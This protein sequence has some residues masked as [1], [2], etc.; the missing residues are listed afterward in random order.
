MGVD[1]SY[2]RCTSYDID[3]NIRPGPE[4]KIVP[5]RND[6]GRRIFLNLFLSDIILRPEFDETLRIFPE[7]EVTVVET[8][9]S[10]KLNGK[11]DY[12][13]EGK[14]MFDNTILREIYVVAVEAKTKFIDKD[15]WQC[16]AEAASLYKTNS[17]SAYGAIN[18][19]YNNGNS[20]LSMKMDFRGRKA[21]SR[22]LTDRHIFGDSFR[23]WYFFSFRSLLRRQFSLLDQFVR[24]SF[25]LLLC[26]F[27]CIF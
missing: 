7:L 13:V 1:T 22:Y 20:F 8:N 9:D 24:K 21:Y 23:K 5:Q 6:A 12:T 26:A 4:W 10:K 19:M 17:I 18:L 15:I 27:E 11:T 25:S 16:A 2:R 3:E 14:D